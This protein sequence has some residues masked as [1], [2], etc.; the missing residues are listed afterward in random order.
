MFVICMCGLLPTTPSLELTLLPP[1]QQSSLGSHK[2]LTTLKKRRKEKENYRWQN[3][4]LL[5]YLCFSFFGFYSSL[6]RQRNDR[7]THSGNS[8]NNSSRGRK[9]RSSFCIYLYICICIFMCM[10]VCV[11]KRENSGKHDDAKER[12][13]SRNN[14]VHFLPYPSNV[15]PGCSPR[16]SSN[17]PHYYSD[18]RVRAMLLVDIHAHTNTLARI[19]ETKN[20]RNRENIHT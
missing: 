1:L 8:S 5:L 10:C 15:Q 16:A 13:I 4:L 14:T 2:T 19:K 20:K 17:I 18:Y 7:K 6:Q 11:R 12:G 9:S 3:L